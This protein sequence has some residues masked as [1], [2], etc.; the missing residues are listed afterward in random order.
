MGSPA[1]V[2]LT[3]GADMK[4]N[5]VS[6]A[7]VRLSICG[8][9]LVLIAGCGGGSG[10][11]STGRGGGNPTTVTFTIPEALRAGRYRIDIDNPH[12]QLR[13]P[14]QPS[15]IVIFTVTSSSPEMLP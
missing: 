3:L 15:N 5:S 9:A 10:G 14:I 1:V 11:G 6:C 12:E 4:R 13:N 2:G 7:W 8:L